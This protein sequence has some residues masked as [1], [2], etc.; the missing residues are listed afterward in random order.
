M[1]PLLIYDHTDAEATFSIPSLDGVHK[2]DLIGEASAST[3][4]T[5]DNWEQFRLLAVE[6]R[7]KELDPQLAAVRQ[8]VSIVLPI[9]EFC[10]LSAEEMET[11]ICGSTNITVEQLK[12]VV[13]THL[14]DHHRDMFW[15]VMSLFASEERSQFL[16]FAC[17]YRRLPQDV[18]TFPARVTVGRRAGSDSSFPT[19]GTCSG[20]F[21]T[22][23]YSSVERMAEMFRVALSCTDIDAD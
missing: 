22:P 23:L 1:L 13:T 19:A 17:G 2:I 10:L 8:G 5:T 16:R 15:Q 3:L 12:A 7:L 14:E 20:N 6:A 18:S 11:Q 9:N 21:N 4:V